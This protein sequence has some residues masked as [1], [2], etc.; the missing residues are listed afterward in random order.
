MKKRLIPND[1]SI[2]E[3]FRIRHDF[4]KQVDTWSKHKRFSQY[5]GYTPEQYIDLDELEQVSGVRCFWRKYIG[6]NQRMLAG[7]EL[8]NIEAYT[9]FVLKYS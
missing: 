3:Q 9:M 4:L 6:E 1:I 7:F 2:Y 8:V 5:V